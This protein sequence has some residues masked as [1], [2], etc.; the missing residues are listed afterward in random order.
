MS[1]K[2]RNSLDSVLGQ[3]VLQFT[4]KQGKAEHANYKSIDR[5]LLDFYS[6]IKTNRLQRTQ[7]LQNKLTMMKEAMTRN[8]TDKIRAS[9]S[10]KGLTLFEKKL[11]SEVEPQGFEE[12]VMGEQ[13]DEE[14]LNYY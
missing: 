3:K 5:S 12:H 11:V 6:N 14:E 2:V 7:D 1:Q 13:P 4:K 8:A 10:D 9:G